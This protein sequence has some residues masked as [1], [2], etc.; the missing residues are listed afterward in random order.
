MT[1]K[2]PTPE[3]PAEKGENKEASSP[4]VS[5][6]GNAEAAPKQ[7]LLVIDDEKDVHYSFKRL[8]ESEGTSSE[9]IQVLSAESGDEGL[10]ILKAQPVDVVVMDIRMGNQNGLE[11]LKQIRQITSKQVVIMMT[12]YG[13]SQ[14]A[15]EAMKL[16]AYDYILKPFDIG[17]LKELL[18]RALEAARMLRTEMPL[19]AKLT[20]MESQMIVGNA[21]AMQSV[22]KIIGQVAPTNT[23]V[24]ITGESGTG[25]EMI[26]RAIYQNSPRNNKVFIAI[27]CTAIPENLL[28]SEL[29][30]HERGSFT[31]A[32]NQRIGKFELG[33]GG[34]IFLDEIGDMPVTT[35]AKIL[36]VLQEGEICRLGNNDPIKTD[37][38]II[39]ATN[40]DLAEAVKKR[41]FREDLFY[42]LNV[43][44]LHLPR[45]SERRSDI[46][47]LVSYFLQKHRAKN[48]SGPLQVTAD[49]LDAL[50]S[51]DWPG[52]VRELENIVQRAMVFATGASI[53]I[54]HLPE[55]IAG[56]GSRTKAEPSAEERLF[57][58]VN[59]LI[60][61][62]RTRGQ[63]EGATLG[64]FELQLARRALE[65]S[66]GDE[67]E[68]SELLGIAPA[69]LKRLLGG[70]GR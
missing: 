62:F 49:A 44:N 21:A 27:N 25:K 65:E 40:K 38:R 13:T 31:G 14:T 6:A 32:M 20:P 34:T 69:E 70:K 55:A 30:G 35:Q 19:P 43:V 9:T 3:K 37:V 52:N 5:A 63:G 46:P 16:G 28:E 48:P 23:T 47:A 36:R 50:T 54:A 29:F 67:K 68:A 39:A 10:K 45:L 51:Y 12:A 18:H 11:T 59:D 61:A 24:L 22:Y 57:P 17:Q 8:L 66:G 60:A 15:I 64:D 4:S 26:A 41:E 2:S 1:K 56:Q 53:Q 7:K 33:D 58:V 42:R